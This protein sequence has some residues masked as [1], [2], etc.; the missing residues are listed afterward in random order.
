MSFLV[1]KNFTLSRSTSEILET[2][3]SYVYLVSLNVVRTSSSFSV[4]TV[5]PEFLKQR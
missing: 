4:I 2:T 5:G 3:V 1:Y